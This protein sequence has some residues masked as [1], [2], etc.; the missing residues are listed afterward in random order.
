MCLRLEFI[1][2]GLSLCD[3][4]VSP[5]VVAQLY[6][7]MDALACVLRISMLEFALDTNPTRV[8]AH[9]K[10]FKYMMENYLFN[11][12]H[13]KQHCHS[14]CVLGHFTLSRRPWL[15][16]THHPSAIS[17]IWHSEGD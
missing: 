2:A 12:E 9:Y 16:V 4:R 11:V 14:V 17:I 1:T 15:T 5:L 7:S 8:H 3:V 13:N 10:Q 6:I